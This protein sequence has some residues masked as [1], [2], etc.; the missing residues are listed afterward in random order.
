M[1]K[2]LLSYYRIVSFIFTSITRNSKF[3]FRFL[4]AQNL[5][6]RDKISTISLRY[7]LYCRSVT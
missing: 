5:H 3:A 2:Y 6:K 4:A 7:Y 1:E